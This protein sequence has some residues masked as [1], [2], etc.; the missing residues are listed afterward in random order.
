MK[1]DAVFLFP[2][3]PLFFS[4]FS[5]SAHPFLCLGHPSFSPG[6]RVSVQELFAGASKATMTLAFLNPVSSGGS[7]CTSHLNQSCL[8]ASN[9]RSPKSLLF[10]SFTFLVLPK[11]VWDPGASVLKRHSGFHTAL[12][13]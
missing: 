3:P 13:C 6:S 7:H 12:L 2:S 11:R 1:D 9:S 4:S 5:S 10:L 8:S